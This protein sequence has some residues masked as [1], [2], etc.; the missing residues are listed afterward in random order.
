MT[1]QCDLKGQ[2]KLFFL[3]Q[4]RA[5]S[6]CK[7][8]GESL[9]N[10]ATI[11]DITQHW[12]SEHLAMTLGTEVQSCTVCWQTESQGHLSYRQTKRPPAQ[13]T[14]DLYLDNACNQMCSYCSAK[15]S[16][17]WATSLTQHGAFTGISA[18]TKTNM[19]GTQGSTDLDHWLE[20]IQSYIQQQPANSVKIKLAGGEPLMQIKQLQTLVD[21][22]GD[23]I[24]QIMV[25][26]NLNPPNNKF[27][28]WLLRRV[29]AHKL[30]F[31]ISL[32]AA[33]KFNHVPRAG[34]QIDK[35]L[36]NL[37]LVRRSGV[38][39]KF[40]CV[41]SVLNIF[42][43]PEYVHW[44]EQHGYTAEY[45]PLFNPDCLDARLLP[46]QFKQQIDQSA[47]PALAQDVLKAEQ[48]KVDL[49]LFEQ[50]NYLKQYFNRTAIDPVTT[51]NQHWN[52][53]WQ[54]LTERYQ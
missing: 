30:C 14:I 6:C 10:F 21:F 25:N 16:S 39:F 24:G 17:T 48:L 51:S 8:Y 50:Y 2:Q 47:L 33:P 38:E 9:S 19:Q 49:K 45:F 12:S 7:A 3:N 53:Y 34:F 26:T 1:K 40:L 35:F 13:D 36:E 52:Q 46:N 23:R 28:L 31:D 42:A 29:P 11:D 32:D 15:F 27:L 54:W 20:Q 5:A 4:N 44:I 43:L 41:I 37:D 18:K 22:A